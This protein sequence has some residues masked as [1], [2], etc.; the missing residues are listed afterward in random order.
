VTIGRTEA[1]LNV[2]SSALSRTHAS[3]AREGG[4]ILLRDLGSRNGTQLRGQNIPEQ[5][6]VLDAVSLTL[7][8]E[9]SLRLAPST[10]V[11]GALAIEVA[12]EHYVAPLGEA[13]VGVGSWQLL[14]TE[15][16]WVELVTEGGPPAFTGGMRLV[17]RVT[18]LRGDS[19]SRERVGNAV[20]WIE[21]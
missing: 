14:E 1:T 5:L 19:F 15:D 7:G 8:S 21:E 10:A 11:E 17:S 20:L 2:T 4:R 12:G 9:V 13:T 3:L 6:E 16:G 18:L